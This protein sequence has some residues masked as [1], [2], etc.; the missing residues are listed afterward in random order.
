[1]PRRVSVLAVRER[2]A[3]RIGRVEGEGRAGAAR[4]GALRAEELGAEN[5]G[6]S[7]KTLRRHHSNHGLE[8]VGAGRGPAGEDGI[9]FVGV[10]RGIIR[11]ERTGVADHPV[12]LRLRQAFGA[13]Q[14]CRMGECASFTARPFYRSKISSAE[15]RPLQPRRVQIRPIQ[16]RQNEIRLLQSCQ[17]ELRFLQ[18]CESEVNP[19][20]KGADEIRAPEILGRQVGDGKL[21]E[22]SGAVETPARRERGARQAL[23]RAVRTVLGDSPVIGSGRPC[24]HGAGRLLGGVRVGERVHGE[25]PPADRIS[26]END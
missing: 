22:E 11:K 17:R 21:S 3:V 18:P 14:I 26:C 15:V 25:N 6:C 16:S 12:K 23:G 9:G 1:M 13:T 4:F 10:W 19:R 7:F 2:V 20:E 8:K 5:F 24:Q